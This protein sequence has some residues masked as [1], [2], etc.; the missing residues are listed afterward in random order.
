MQT[1]PTLPSPNL[2]LTEAL[3]IEGVQILAGHDADLA[4]V[5]ERFGP[6]PLWA[7]E[8][9]FPTLVYIILEQQVSLA[10]A[11]AAFQRLAAAISPLTPQ[12]FL[13][14]SD[15]ELKAIGFSRQKTGYARLLAQSI[16]AGEID[17][18]GLAAFED[19]AVQARLTRLKGVG[20]WSADIYLME[21]LL[22]PDV[23]PSGD[24]ALAI[25][26]QRVKRLAAVP[27]P[28][29]LEA[30]GEA[31]RPWRAVA[32]RIFWHYYLSSPT[33]RSAPGI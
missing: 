26:V 32:A 18:A 12:A 29:E 27:G 14:L 6:P 3:L 19:G 13:E 21:A 16:L 20:R 31:Y 5:Y 22:R 2:V 7:R 11:R 23:W 8:P 33:R 9:G 4:A 10:S 1:Q 28:V 24:L 15:A 30:I 25:A 17:L